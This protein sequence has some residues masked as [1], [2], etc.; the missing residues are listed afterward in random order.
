MR[1]KSAN[2]AT[3]TEQNLHLTGTTGT[4]ITRGTWPSIFLIT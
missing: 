4:D 3:L 1:R 2:T